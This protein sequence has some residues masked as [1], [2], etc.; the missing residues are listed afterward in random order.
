M[1]CRYIFFSA[2]IDSCFYFSGT[3]STILHLIFTDIITLIAL[4]IPEITTINKSQWPFSQDNYVIY[5]GTDILISTAQIYLIILLNLHIITQTNIVTNQ[6]NQSNNIYDQI[7][8][9]KQ[10][11]VKWPIVTVWILAISVSTPVYHLSSTIVNL[12]RNNIV[13]FVLL[14]SLLIFIRIVI[15]A[16]MLFIITLDLVRLLIIKRRDFVCFCLYLNGGLV[17]FTGHKT[18]LFLRHFEMNLNEGTARYGIANLGGDKELYFIVVLF[19]YGYISL[20][21][22]SYFIF[23]DLRRL[24][25]KKN[26]ESPKIC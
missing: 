23:K 15:P 16:L 13:E 5:L 9:N 12:N 19:F 7:T 10:L 2:K 24:F 6:Q 22:L 11:R 25:V 18:V 4:A 21:W 3:Y 14:E 26:D 8:T 17:L 20:R 1:C